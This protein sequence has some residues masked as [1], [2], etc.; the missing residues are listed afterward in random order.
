MSAQSDPSPWPTHTPPNLT[1][2]STTP[3]TSPLLGRAEFSNLARPDAPP[4]LSKSCSDK[5]ALKQCTSLLSSTSSLLLHPGNAYL[6]NLVIPTSQ[7]VPHAC[8]RAL[9]EK[10]RMRA[11]L[12]KEG[13]WG[14]GYR[15]RGMT[16]EGTSVDFEWSRRA[17]GKKLVASNVA[18]VAIGSKSEA[19]IGG[20][21]MGSKVG[22]DGVESMI[23][24]RAEWDRLRDVWKQM[25]GEKAT[26]EGEGQLRRWDD[27]L[28]SFE[29]Y[30]AFKDRS[31][32]LGPRR[33]VKADV[34]KLAL[35]GWQRNTGDSFRINVE[36]SR[37][38]RVSAAVSAAVNEDRV[39]WAVKIEA[40]IFSNDSGGGKG[41]VMVCGGVGFWVVRI[42]RVRGIAAET[43]GVGVAIWT[44]SVYGL[45]NVAVLQI[46]NSSSNSESGAQNELDE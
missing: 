36:P 21:K 20:V 38:S 28:A 12:D 2:P 34:R 10:G 27:V 26:D 29:D 6:A 31:E 5:L 4:T 43:K 22:K 13:S 30:D 17:E 23:S 24:R 25:E 18:A 14:G 37:S 35:M 8:E 45:L 46:P 42:V 7:L 40:L 41:R 16:V 3:S 39:G 9:G 32:M 19:L 44:Q 15:L 1:S 11:V 33:E